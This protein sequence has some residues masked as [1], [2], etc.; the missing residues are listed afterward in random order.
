VNNAVALHQVVHGYDRGHGLLAGSITLS[1]RDLDLVT[2]LSDLSGQLTDERDFHPYLTLYPLP[3]RIFYA[4][5]RTWLDPLADRSGCVLTH[6]LLVPLDAWAT[7]RYPSALDDLLRP[8]GRDNLAPYSRTVSWIPAIGTS[9][10]HP[11]ASPAFS[12][13]FAQRYFLEG[14]RPIVWLAEPSAD[15]VAWPIVTFL[16]PTLRSVFTCCTLAFQQRDHEDHPF[17][18]LFSPPSATARFSGLSKQHIVGRE[19]IGSRP[20][21]QR[22]WAPRLTALIFAANANEHVRSLAETAHFGHRDHS[23]RAIVISEIGRS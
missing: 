17:D 10:P 16:W 19:T 7:C 21:A 20:D 5:A 13:T 9:M 23:D 22:D 8:P 6:T 12:P 11:G 15:Q 2:R 1:A 3:S 14:I 4:V 18:L